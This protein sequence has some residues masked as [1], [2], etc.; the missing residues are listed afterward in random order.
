M[1]ANATSTALPHAEVPTAE[2]FKHI[3]ADLT[4]P[5]RMRCLLGWCGSRA[6]PPKPDAPQSKSKEA[7]AEFQALQA[8]R[9]IQEE[10][11][12]DLVSKGTLSDW[13]SRDDE[14]QAQASLVKKPNPRNVANAA[15]A[16]ELERELERCVTTITPVKDAT[17]T[18]VCRL[19][20]ERKE[21]ETLMSSAVP[22][23]AANPSDDKTSNT[24]AD[25]G[26]LSP[27][28]S[29]LLSSPDRAI[30]AQL[31]QSSTAPE[32]IEQRLQHISTNLEFSIDQFA[33]GV[34]AM[35][36][37]RDMAERV[38]D[39]SLKDAAEVLEDRSKERREKSGS[40]APME[41]LRGL[42]RVLNRG[43]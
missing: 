8:A 30:F 20:K 39:K 38:A 15:K 4:E 32:D 3:S 36:T 26:A 33:D 19:K 17:L 12:S 29:D 24:N 7:N 41:A 9:V 16:E 27:L 23:P 18:R 35:A 43:R 5:R 40:V 14:P 25:P 22:K 1:A 31:N 42:A 28:H 34:H 2:F 37:T 10:L 6:L 13:F 11:S 21:W